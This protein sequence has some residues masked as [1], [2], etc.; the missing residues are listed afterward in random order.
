M[1]SSDIKSVPCPKISDDWGAIKDLHEKLYQWEENLLDCQK[2]FAKKNQCSLPHPAYDEVT[3]DGEVTADREEDCLTAESFLLVK[4]LNRLKQ[5]S[6][7]VKTCQNHIDEL[8]NELRN[9]DSMGGIDF[10]GLDNP[11][12]SHEDS[13]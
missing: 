3:E 2:K 4:S 7:A 10:L 9:E 12:C 6:R 1:L 5:W 11:H 8:K 13:V